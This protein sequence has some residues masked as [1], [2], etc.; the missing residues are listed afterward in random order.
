M[1][2]WGHNCQQGAHM[3]WQSAGTVPHLK[4]STLTTEYCVVFAA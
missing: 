4:I 2:T 1:I 3:Y